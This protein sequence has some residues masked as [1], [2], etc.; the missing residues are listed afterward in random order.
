MVG[1]ILVNKLL[2][3]CQGIHKSKIIAS[4]LSYIPK[5][6]IILRSFYDINNKVREDINNAILDVIQYVDRNQLF[7][8][9]LDKIWEIE[10]DI[11]NPISVIKSL[12][13]IDLKTRFQDSEIIIDISAGPIPAN[14]GLYLFA[15]RHKIPSVHF[16]FP[17]ERFEEGN[18]DRTELQQ[19][20]FEI[21]FARRHSYDI[22]II[23]VV[24]KDIDD[25]IIFE[26]AKT[27][28]VGSLKKLNEILARE[29]TA[30]TLM[31]LSRE[32]ARLDALDL[33]RTTRT[34]K[35]KEISISS[36]GRQYSEF[37]KFE[38]PD[39]K[40]VWERR[41]DETNYF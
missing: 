33:I 30:K 19:L 35:L 3:L 37:K 36:F 13:S 31:N 5:D 11:I 29:D 20:Q 23:D 21:E 8:Q 38:R 40:V 28:K 26:L 39:L 17:G 32:C 27:G 18:R 22:P 15:L 14:V 7:F 16:S 25:E 41:T 12:E 6:C 34:R 4:I 24:F 9:K 10:I 2:I 1:Y